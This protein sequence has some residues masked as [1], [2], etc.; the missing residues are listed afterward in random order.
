MTG[1]YSASGEAGINILEFSKNRGSLEFINSFN[2]GPNPSFLCLNR[3]LNLIYAINEVDTFMNSVAG[4]L[5]TIRHDGKFGNLQTAGNIPVP[6][7]G[8][9]YISIA[10]GNDYLLVANYGG[11]SA[12][13]VSLNKNG[14]P[15]AVTDTIHFRDVAG[16]I[17]HAHKIAFDP[18]GQR[19][20]VTD[21]GLD[22]IW[23][24]TLD[25]L[26]GKLI[27]SQPGRIE[28]PKGTGPRHFVFNE[29]GTMLYIIGELNSTVSVLDLNHRDSIKVVQTISTLKDGFKGDNAC[30][31]IHID[32]SG[33]YLYGSNRGENSIVTY[34][35][36]SDGL[37]TMA[38]HSDCGGNWPRNFTIDP[39]GE[40]M[41]VANQKSDNIAVFRINRETGI[42]SEKVNEIRLMSP[43]CLKFN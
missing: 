32:R 27:K 2:A 33:K 39:S 30:A 37:L 34:R 8:P 35:I 23:I 1:S 11:G 18:A 21:L 15:E 13:V 29:S 41:L 26:T 16:G 17:S 42:P 38:G 4:G 31:D 19:V 20:F 6:N 28:L 5:T 22:C 24:F 7:G 9:C 14:I 12:A 40:F 3:E 36:G 43:V 10:P 25:R